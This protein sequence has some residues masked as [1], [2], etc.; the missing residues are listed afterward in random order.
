VDRL[1]SGRGGNHG[2][3]YRDSRGGYKG[4]RF[5]GNS[6]FRGRLNYAHVSLYK[7]RYY[8]YSKKGYWLNK[9]T[10][11]ERDRA[12]NEFKRVLRNTTSAIYYYFLI[13]FKG[14]K[15]DLKEVRREETEQLLAEVEN[16]V[17]LYKD[18]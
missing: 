3:N 13:D 11:E 18:E 12:Y 9:H 8:I 14:L 16:I 4:G 2:Q 17:N 1:Y 5:R 6:G 10:Q 15:L 7:K